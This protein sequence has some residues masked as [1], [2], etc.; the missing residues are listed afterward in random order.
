MSKA[1]VNHI[2][3]IYYRFSCHFMNALL[4]IHLNKNDN[5]TIGAQYI[6]RNIFFT[7]QSNQESV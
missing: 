1:K 2:V 4:I 3:V 5:M 7:H 6:T